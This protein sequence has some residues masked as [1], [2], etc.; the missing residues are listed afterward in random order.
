[1]RAVE[2]RFG[3]Q[4]RMGPYWSVGRV[5]RTWAGNIRIAAPPLDGTQGASVECY[6]L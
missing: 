5:E 3:R 6:L 1:M 4:G 2:A